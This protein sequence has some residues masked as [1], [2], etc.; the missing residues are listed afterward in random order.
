MSEVDTSSSRESHIVMPSSSARADAAADRSALA[1]A[2][3]RMPNAAAR[4]ATEKPMEPR[5]M[6]PMVDPSNPSALL[7]ALLS[8]WPSRTSLTL[9]A[10]RRSIASSR[11]RVSSAT[12]A[13]FRPGTLQTNTPW[14]AAASVSMVFVPAP[15]R[16]TSTSRSAASNTARRTFVLRTTSPS[17][18]AIRPASSSAA[19]PGSITQVCP[20]ASRSTMVC[21]GM[22]SANSR[23]ITRPP[24][25]AGRRGRRVGW[26]Q[27]N[28]RTKRRAM[29][30][31]AVTTRRP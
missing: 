7:Y 20:R 6:M 8:Q 29:A 4:S 26:R 21:S 15:A 11:P 1:S 22:R 28:A 14:L 18:P 3:T 23:C 25:R 9:S 17:N 10:I 12:A 24:G 16:I 2:C 27:T 5:P 19:R 13:A 30:G 31:P